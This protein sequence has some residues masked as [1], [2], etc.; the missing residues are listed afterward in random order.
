MP[1]AETIMAVLWLIRLPME[2]LMHG[3]R[4]ALRLHLYR[5]WVQALIL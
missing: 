4:E 3:S 5:L 1:P 2:C